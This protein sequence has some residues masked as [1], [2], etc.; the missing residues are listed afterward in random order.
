MLLIYRRLRGRGWLTAV[1]GS[2]PFP[3]SSEHQ[4]ALTTE[5]NS[6]GAA[7]VQLGPNQKLRASPALKAQGQLSLPA[8]R[9]CQRGGPGPGAPPQGFALHPSFVGSDQ[10]GAVAWGAEIDVGSGGPDARV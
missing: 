9:E 10:P 2:D 8:G 3:H 7:P 4:L 5:P 6:G 1:R